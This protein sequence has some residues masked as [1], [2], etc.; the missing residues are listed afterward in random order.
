MRL[1]LIRIRK[2]LLVVTNWNFLKVFIKYRV[3]ATFQHSYV[4]DNRHKT[5]IDIGANRGQFAL[6]ASINRNAKIFAFEP[7][8]APANIF[9][10]VFKDNAK[11]RLFRAAIGEAVNQMP[12]HVSA[13]DDSSSL[14][15]LLPLQSKLFP[16][17]HEIR[18]DTISVAPLHEF[19]LPTDIVSPSLLK[20]DVQGYEL[21]ALRGCEQ[22]FHIIDQIYCECSFMALYKDQDLASD[23]IVY[24]R[25]FG[26]QLVGVFNLKTTKK[27]ESIQAD[28]LFEK[29]VDSDLS[30]A[31]N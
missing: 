2:L 19:L 22:F 29:F 24:L 23:V 6:A 21:R 25:G 4:L 8:S 17:T 31:Q 3:L 13:K 10:E 1:L 27:G 12:I 5:I 9:Q 18:V 28:L 11:L 26:Y 15:E 7:L 14:L 20:L 16:G 30:V